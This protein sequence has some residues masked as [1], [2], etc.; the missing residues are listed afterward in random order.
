MAGRAGTDWPAEEAPGLGR[1]SV[2][3]RCRVLPVRLPVTAVKTEAL[4]GHG[5]TPAVAPP[6]HSC[7]Q[8]KPALLSLPGQVDFLAFGGRRLALCWFTLND[9]HSVRELCLVLVSG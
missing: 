9:G 8:E 1:V 6:L 2:T 5:E 7:G 4:P 3:G